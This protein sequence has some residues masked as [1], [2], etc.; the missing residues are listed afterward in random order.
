ME[1]FI[2]IYSMVAILAIII[3]I[4]FTRWLFKI[5]SMEACQKSSMLLLKK[6][7]EKAGVDQEAINEALQPY[8]KMK[9]GRF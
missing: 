7:A 6:M 2:F 4:F 5:D 1:N 3:I 9:T 8:E